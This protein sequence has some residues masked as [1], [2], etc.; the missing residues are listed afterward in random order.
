[1]AA[2]VSALR[3]ASVALKNPANRHRAVPLTFEQ[4]HYSFANAVSEDKAKALFEKY[5]VP[6]RASRSSRQRPADDTHRL[7]GHPRNPTARSILSMPDTLH[8]NK[9]PTTTAD[10]FP[11]GSAAGTGVR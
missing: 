1:M 9:R 11:T 10:L 5:A 7:R 2:S 8:G 6:D 3:S 4:F